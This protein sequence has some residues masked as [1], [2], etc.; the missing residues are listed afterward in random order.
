[1]QGNIEHARSTVEG[2][3]EKVNQAYESGELSKAEVLDG[4]LDHLYD[5]LESAFSEL[6]EDGP[7][8][9]SVR[10]PEQLHDPVPYRGAGDSVDAESGMTEYLAD[11][12]NQMFVNPPNY[13]I[14][15]QHK[16][17]NLRSAV[18]EY[19]GAH[20]HLTDDQVIEAAKDAYENIGRMKAMNRPSKNP[21]LEQ[22]LKR[23]EATLQGESTED[24]P[25]MGPG[26][27]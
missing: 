27:Q 9:A 18:E 4:K 7:R 12:Y 21:E 19:G 3:M 20:D 8:L 14:D 26:L 25:E 11:A 5:F 24:D 23:V 6:E 1:M 15:Y 2:L 17:G 13:P 16:I 22:N 10:Y